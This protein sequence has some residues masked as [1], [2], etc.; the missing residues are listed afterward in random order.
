M[1]HEEEQQEKQKQQQDQEKEKKKEHEN[2]EMIAIYPT[3]VTKCD[4]SD[5]YDVPFVKG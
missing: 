2:T 5:N 3:K 4:P 1:E